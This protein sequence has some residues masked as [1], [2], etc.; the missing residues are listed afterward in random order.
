VNKH[1]DFFKHSDDYQSL[2]CRLCSGISKF[3][4][5]QLLMNVKVVKYFECVQCG[6][7]QTEAPDWL[8]LAYAENLAAADTGAGQRTLRNLVLTYFVSK[9]LHVENILDV[10]GGD[11]LLCRFLRDYGL[12]CFVNDKY[13]KPIYAQD[14]TEP[15]F[16]CPSLL[17]AFEVVEHFSEPYLELTKIF[18]KDSDFYLFSTGI[19]NKQNKDWWYLTPQTGQH[20]FFYSYRG[21]DWIASKFI[22]KSIKVGNLVF[23]YKKQKMNYFQFFF[24]WMLMH[25]G[26]TWVL[27]SVLVM[28]PTFGVQRDHELVSSKNAL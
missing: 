14:F 27:R 10:G 11:G 22:Y 12:N 7:L 15:N 8:E 24:V 18:E 16:K 21:L 17:L 2:G 4:F 26:V 1:S 19:Y 3:K 6:C 13:S 28:L 23:F 9:I 5:E 20:V 25:R